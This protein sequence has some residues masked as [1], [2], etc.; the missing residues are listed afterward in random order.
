MQK[1]TLVAAV[2]SNGCIGVGNDMPWHIPE[3]LKYFKKITSN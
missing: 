3:E 1:I 2:G